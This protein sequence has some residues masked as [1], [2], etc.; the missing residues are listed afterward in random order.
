MRLGIIAL[1]AST[2]FLTSCGSD[3]EQQINL[4]FKLQYDNAP[5]VMFEEVEYPDGR[6]FEFTRFSFYISDVNLVSGG[7]AE[8]ILD[9][10]YLDL[11]TS[12]S[13][14]VDAEAGYDLTIDFE[15]NSNY[16]EIQMNFGL[17]DAQNDT[18]P[19]DYGSNSP[20]SL[21]GEYWSSWESYV[22]VK[23]EGRM[24]LDNDGVSDGVALHLGSDVIRRAISVDQLNSTENLT[25][26]IDTKKIFERNG[27]IYD[28]DTTPRIHS[29][30]QLDQATILMDNFV[31]SIS[32]SN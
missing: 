14:A 20:L 16:D 9:V 28:I 25:F 27:E 17:T 7:E 3:E 11:T 5:L 32:V 21:S 23:I 29:L 8:Q 4:N 19:E 26:T 15:G 2:I 6:N 12:H 1:F 30:S 10:A 18:K 24:D 22:Y 31:N 13:T